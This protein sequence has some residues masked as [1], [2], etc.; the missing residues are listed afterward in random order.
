MASSDWEDV[1]VDA[2]AEDDGW[3]D[4]P[5]AAD[6]PSFLQ[7]AVRGGLDALPIA[8]GL[9]GGTLGTT[10]GPVGTVGGGALGYAAGRQLERLGKHYLLGDALPSQDIQDQATQVGADLAEGALAEMGGPILSKGMGAVATKVPQL[11]GKA[12]EKL[13]VKS[14]GATGSHAAKFRPDTGRILLD[15]GVVQP[16]SSR[17]KIL[18]RASE[19]QGRGAGAMDEALSS[20]N[21]RVGPESIVSSIDDK[22]VELSR[23]PGNEKRVKVLQGMRDRFAKRVGSDKY[24]ASDVEN[25]KR[26]YQGRVNYQS[27]AIKPQST[28]A[29]MDMASLL[30]NQTE[31]MVGDASPQALELFKKGKN[32]YGAMDPVA[33]MGKSSGLS[34]VRDD[35]AAYAGGELLDAV[36]PGSFG[37]GGAALALRRLGK[38][39][40]ISSSAAVGLD[41]GSKLASSIFDRAK[42][43]M[44]L[45]SRGAAYL[46]SKNSIDVSRA[47]ELRRRSKS[48]DKSAAQ[49]DFLMSQTDP[50]YQEEKKLMFE[51]GQ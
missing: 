50:S 23:L 48:G 49:Q 27:Q 32:L 14:T 19:A 12:A 1:P 15:E 36:T 17:A 45:L 3:E 34:G 8:G 47:I 31:S 20:V 25:M 30:R 51:G 9:A 38:T 24:S 13:A 29:N 26:L 40:P 18:Q 39:A 41:R 35:I 2:S 11:M 5:V 44:P 21:N 10:A 33:K 46:G 42:P 16:L 6:E 22:I 28:Q 4:V 7:K 37:G 43:S